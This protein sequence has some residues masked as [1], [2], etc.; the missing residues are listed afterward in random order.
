MQVHILL[1]SHTAHPFSNRLYNFNSTASQDPSLDPTYAEQL[2]QQCPRGSLD[3]SL[4]IPMDPP[5]PDTVDNSYYAGIIANRGL[6]TSDQTLLS[7]PATANQVRV[8]EFNEK[9]W[10]RNFA[11]AMVKMSLWERGDRRDGKR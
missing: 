5:S 4:D 7:S 1:G 9:M 3:D 2:K 6:F 10:R 11:Q 8:N